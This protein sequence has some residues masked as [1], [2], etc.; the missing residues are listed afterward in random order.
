M[1][2]NRFL[3]SVAESNFRLSEFLALEHLDLDPAPGT[4]A[5]PL[6]DR[7]PL[8]L[9]SERTLEQL[10]VAAG[11]PYR[12]D[13]LEDGS[14]YRYPLVLKQSTTV[15]TAMFNVRERLTQVISL[16]QDFDVPMSQ[17]RANGCLRDTAVDLLHEVA[18]FFAVMEI[19]V[20]ED[21]NRQVKNSVQAS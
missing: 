20:V 17:H 4:P 19:A 8:A 16:M 21:H 9:N 15:R 1:L 14:C 2:T 18:S 7:M 5:V 13:M 10:S 3:E 6:L 11:N 12:Y